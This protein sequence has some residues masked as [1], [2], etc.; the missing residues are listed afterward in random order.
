MSVTGVEESVSSQGSTVSSFVSNDDLVNCLFCGQRTPGFRDESC[1]KCNVC[2]SYVHF[3]CLTENVR[4]AECLLLG[5]VFY[6]FTCK[7][8]SPTGLEIVTKEKVSWLTVLVLA[9]YNL[10]ELQHLSRHGFFHWKLHIADFID[11]KWNYIF[12]SA[13]RRKRAWHGTVSGTLSHYSPAFFQT[14]THVLRESGWWKLT[15]ENMSPFNTIRLKYGG[16]GKRSSVRPT[17]EYEPNEEDFNR[18]T[19]YTSSDSRPPSAIDALP[20][21]NTEMLSY[22]DSES[23][24]VDIDIPTDLDKM[25]FPKLES[26]LSDLIDQYVTSEGSYSVSPSRTQIMLKNGPS[27]LGSYSSDSDSGSSSESNE[28]EPSIPPPKSLL[29]CRKNRDLPWLKNCVSLVNNTQG[30]VPMTEYEELNLLQLLSKQIESSTK[31]IPSAILRLHRKLNVRREQRHRRLGHFSDVAASVNKVNL[32]GTGTLQPSNIRTLDRYQVVTF[33]EESYNIKSNQQS[34]MLRLLGRVE[35]TCF[36]SPYT[37]RLLK[38][39][40]RRDYHSLPLWTQLMADLHR[41]QGTQYQ[42]YPID[43]SYVQPHHIPAVNSLCELFFW[44]GIDLSESLMYP[45]FSCVALYRKLVVGFAFM[46][47]DVS[48]NE[49][50]ISFLFTRPEWRRAG[51]ATFMVYH[52]IQT[53]MGKDVTLHVS[54]TNPA[55]MLYQKFGFKVEEL[56]QDFYDKYL[57]IDS[58]E[59]KHALFLRLSR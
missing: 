52:L 45:D 36:V 57:P 29:Q 14:G 32:S 21:L 50:Y 49:S 34:F 55:V 27:A 51:I 42:R 8:C 47:P 35:P 6:K 46:V 33:S 41:R 25:G 16:I 4:V 30:C 37:E 19:S 17:L 59:C 39:F 38:P 12:G 56:A 3:A 1:L 31:S 58:K 24:D 7:S 48:Y 40:I 18:Q 43:Y 11:R 26:E 28:S 20:D 44:P 5:D 23:L 53:C 54:V 10:Q 9:L 13:V 2:D 22:S 15:Y